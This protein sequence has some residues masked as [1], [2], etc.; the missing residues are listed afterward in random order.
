M[1]KNL[2]K[3]TVGTA[4]T[5]GMLTCSMTAY[6]ATVDDVAEVARQF[7]YPEDVINQAY[8]QYYAEP[9]KYTSEDFDEAIAY[10]YEAEGIIM[11]TG[12]QNPEPV[13]TS[14]TTVTTTET[15]NETSEAG[16]T[17]PEDVNDNVQPENTGGVTLQTENGEEFSRITPEEFIN[18]SYD[19]KMNYVRN[20]TP[21]Q[22]QV[23]LNNLTIEERKS[24]LK[25]LPVDQKAEVVNSMA[26][27]GETL[28]INISV[29]EISEDNISLSMRNDDG[30]LVGMVN[31]GV[32]VE[33][34]GYDR[35][36]LLALSAGL[37]AFAGMLVGAVS[38][39]FRTG[40]E[41]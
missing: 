27:F 12:V 39:I 35:R 40:D 2:I 36:G 19:D 9:E 37:I 32:I 24:L 17:T 4:V 33:D 20:F 6:S 5:I 7:G 25:Q 28:D 11:T 15:N 8:A 14:T 1:K 29:E 38:R 18:M 10:L 26:N 13:T 30:E 34:T 41:K 21:E 3:I 23:I 16:E 22:Q 31:A